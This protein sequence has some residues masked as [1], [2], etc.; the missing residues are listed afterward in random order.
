M[1]DSQIYINKQLLKEFFFWYLT[2]TTARNV[3]GF[4][5]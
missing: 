4:L 5:K 2:E 1:D 3:K